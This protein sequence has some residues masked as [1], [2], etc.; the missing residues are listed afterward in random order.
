MH[1]SRFDVIRGEETQVVGVLAKLGPAAAAQ[2]QVI[3]PAT[4]NSPA[5]VATAMMARRCVATGRYTLTHHVG[6]AA[7]LHARHSQ[8]GETCPIDFVRPGARLCAQPSPVGQLICLQLPCHKTRRLAVAV[9]TRPLCPPAVIV[10]QWVLVS[11][12]KI[13]WFSTF[14][15]GESFALYSQVPQAPQAPQT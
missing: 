8:Q 5:A 13:R 1:A 3:P 11:G 9:H 10:L 2:P 14:M 4:R 12:G 6:S 15:T 7:A